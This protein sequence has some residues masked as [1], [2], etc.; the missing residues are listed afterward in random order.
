MFKRKEELLTL[1]QLIS[2]SVDGIYPMQEADWAFS[3]F[4]MYT[5]LIE[6]SEFGVNSRQLL[7]ELIS[8]GIQTRPLW[9]PIPLKQSTLKLSI[10]PLQKRY[11]GR[12]KP[13]D[14]SACHVQSESLKMSSKP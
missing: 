13:K 8:H 7:R 2:K 12:N 3:T 4:W 11:R 5:V 6:E 9:Q 10:L 14:L 1:I